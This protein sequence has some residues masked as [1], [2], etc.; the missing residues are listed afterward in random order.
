MA[1][2]RQRRRACTRTRGAC[3]RAAREAEALKHIDITQSFAKPYVLT[4]VASE[5]AHEFCA[6]GENSRRRRATCV[7]Q[8]SVDAVDVTAEAVRTCLSEKLSNINSTT[9]PRESRSRSRATCMSY[10]PLA[11]RMSRCCSG[12]RA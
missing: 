10:A 11:M 1:R 7:E 6:P 4:S 5:A 8:H 12:T 9:F 2:R 3:H